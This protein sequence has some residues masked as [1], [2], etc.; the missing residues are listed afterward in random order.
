[1]NLKALRAFGIIVTQGSLAAAAKQLNLSQPSVSRLI[2][3]LEEELNLTLFYRTKRSLTLTR[4]GEAFHERT[5][6]I[7]VGIDEIPRIVQDLRQFD[8]QF[9]VVVTHKIAQGLI[10]PAIGLLRAQKP[11]LRVAVDVESRIRFETLVGIKR[12]DL[13]IASLPLPLSTTDVD[14][15]PLYSA[16]TEVILPQSHRLASRKAISAKDIASEPIVGLWP[17]QLWRQHVDEFMTSA[18]VPPNFSVETRHVLMSCQLVRD[19]LGLAFVDRVTA[20]GINL[21]GL[22]MKPVKP[23]RWISFGSISQRGRPLTE[24][25]SLFVECVNQVIER[26]RSLSPENAASIRPTV[27]SEQTD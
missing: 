4:E 17:D 5:K 24:N 22:V 19:G 3:Q 1:M 20:Y 26:I 2:S 14:V 13:A 11:G 21:E 10:S 7:I 27:T 16:R 15:Q 9:K 12:F 25:A 8:Q 18:G 23:E 6:H